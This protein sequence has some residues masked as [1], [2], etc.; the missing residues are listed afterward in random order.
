MLKG[1]K[2]YGIVLAV[3]FT[4]LI[5]MELLSPKPINWSI[6]YS[7]NAKTPF[8]TSA[9]FSMLPTIF[10]KKNIKIAETPLYNTLNKIAFQN[11]N[12]IIINNVFKPD[13]LDTRELLKFVSSGNK[14]FI[15]ANYFEGKFADALKLKTDPYFELES[16]SKTD[17]N[18]FSSIYK[19]RDTVQINF[20]NQNLQKP[21]YYQYYKGIDGSYLNSFD[22]TKST[23]LGINK[24]KKVNFIKFTFGK[25]QIFINTLPEVF[26][27]YHFV[28]IN[29]S[30]V[31]KALSH[32]PDQSTIWDEY[33]KAGNDKSDSPLRVI[34]NNSLLLKAYYLL[35]LSLLLF[36][37]FGT[38]RKQRIIPILPPYK[39]TTLQFVDIV[40]TLYYQTGNHKNIA[41]KKIT[42]FLEYIRSEFQIKT[43]I[44][45]DEFIKRIVCLSGIEEQKVRD[46]F[47]Y[48]SG[49]RLKQKITQQELLKLNKMIEEFQKLSKR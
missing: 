34:F 25:G 7:K 16:I 46:L 26:S 24:N 14:V 15:S 17:S 49:I 37:I 43:T 11:Y 31:Y 4:A 8:G 3:C 30:Y 41:D 21:S 33:Y 19:T 32:L 20:S 48:F 22:T 1:N 12:Y 36:M 6:S 40:G 47:Y 27:N 38:K 45:D 10:Q 9:L 28:N 5:L 42:Y 29:Y 13:T 18:L 2:K 23:V 44:Y 39:N 35:V